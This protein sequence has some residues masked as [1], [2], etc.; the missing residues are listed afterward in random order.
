MK[1]NRGSAADRVI[2]FNGQK[3]FFAPKL[4]RTFSVSLALRQPWGDHTTT[5]A[6]MIQIDQN[7]FAALYVLGFNFLGGDRLSGEIAEIKGDMTIKLVHPPGEEFKFVVE[8][9][10]EKQ[11]IFSVDDIKL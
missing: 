9:P 8:L 4:V 6:T 10:G 3:I 1:G 2:F 11:M 5:G 7:L